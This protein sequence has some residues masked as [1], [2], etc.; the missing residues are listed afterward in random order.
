MKDQKMWNIAAIGYDGNDVM[1]AQK[2]E[3]G[4]IL[5]DASLVVAWS[6]PEDVDDPS[7]VLPD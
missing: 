2:M 1:V 3:D 4:R 5:G 6:V 7:P